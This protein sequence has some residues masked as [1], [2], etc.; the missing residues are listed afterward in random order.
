MM[1]ASQKLYEDHFAGKCLPLMIQELYPWI[2]P[3]RFSLW[4][5][6]G[7]IRGHT[8]IHTEHQAGDII[9]M[10]LVSLVEHYLSESGNHSKTS[11][12]VTAKGH[13][14]CFMCSENG[15][16]FVFDPLPA[17]FSSIHPTKIQKEIFT[18][19]QATSDAQTIEYSALIM[20]LKE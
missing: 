9:I 10:P 7:L 15:R 18:Q 19:F 13:T 3:N 1:V 5:A 2:P 8:A 12:I 16:L 11:I 4:E 20:K 17:S 14:V 6:A